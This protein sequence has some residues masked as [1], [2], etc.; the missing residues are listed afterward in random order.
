MSRFGLGL[1]KK[2]RRA[3]WRAIYESGLKLGLCVLPDNYYVPVANLRELRRT[4]RWRRRSGLE[5]LAID[6]DAQVQRVQEI[7]L[8]YAQEY[9]GNIHFR[10][11][12]V[13]SFGPGFGYIEAQALHAMVRSLKPA[14]IIE[15]GSGVSTYCMLEACKLNKADCGQDAQITCIEP[16]PSPWLLR[17][18]VKLIPRPVQEVD[19]C[20]FMQLEDNDLLFIDSTHTVKIGGDVP[21]LYLEVLPQLRP[22]VMI[23]IHDI[24]LPYNYQRDADR[25]PYQWMET[26]LL[27]AFLAFNNT[28]RIDICLS[29]LH[30]DRRDAL[31][32]IFPEY[33]P[34]PDNDGLTASPGSEGHFPSSTYLRRVAPSLV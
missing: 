21:F 24:Y 8:P 6:L 9:K 33:A 25:T 18:P 2:L 13:G 7:C 12:T 30:Y 23:H 15:V 22:G 20:V 26:S 34:Q 17:A 3:I 27:Q 1:R 19:Q 11:A 31:R 10:E 5:G 14:R 4:G 28:F 32:E 29:H 16:H